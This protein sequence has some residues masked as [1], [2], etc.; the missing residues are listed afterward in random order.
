VLYQ[1]GHASKSHYACH[2][3]WFASHGIAALVMDHIEMGEVEFTHHG[4]YSHAWFHW[5]SRGF[6]PLAVERWNARRNWRS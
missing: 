6:S 1:S 5:Y 2:G 3:A 4:V